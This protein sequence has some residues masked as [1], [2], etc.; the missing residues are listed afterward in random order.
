MAYTKEQ[1]EA[2]K[3][4]AE[5]VEEDNV[6]EAIVRVNEKVNTEK[7]QQEEMVS[8][9]N[10]PL[11][12]TVWVK[13]NCY[14]GLIYISKRTGFTIIWETFGSSQPMT[15]EELVMMRNTDV[16]FFSRNLVKITGFQSSKYADK[17]SV[18][19][20]LKFLQISQYYTDSLC[21][22]DISEVFR[23]SPDKIE[24]RVP[25]MSS[26]VKNSILVRANEMISKGELDS[27]RVISSLEKALGCELCRPS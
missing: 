13:S 16:K 7:P 10:L 5:W 17:Y 15:L 12:T 27:L 20:I 1:R 19:E 22:D 8:I 3:K 26:G 6:T 2:K 23:M 9:D 21:P 11:N 24:E 25:N 14:G 18:E 4:A